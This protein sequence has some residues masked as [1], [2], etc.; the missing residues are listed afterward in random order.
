MK[1]D[2]VG[3]GSTDVDPDSSSG[4]D[5]VEVLAGLQMTSPSFE[6]SDESALIESFLQTDPIVGQ[7]AAC[8]CASLRV[9]STWNSLAFAGPFPTFHQPV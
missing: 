2:Q 4:I 3:E 7:V 8:D 6:Q 1:G 9:G 5:R